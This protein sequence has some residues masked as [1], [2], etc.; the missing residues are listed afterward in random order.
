MFEDHY[1]D[2][3][4]AEDILNYNRFGVTPDEMES[5]HEPTEG[6]EMFAL[7]FEP[8]ESFDLNFPDSGDD[9]F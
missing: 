4:D 6:D 9:D 8:E 2:D 1:P 5:D 3:W 7:N